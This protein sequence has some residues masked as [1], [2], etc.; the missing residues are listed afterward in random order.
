MS[1]KHLFN[2]RASCQSREG[3][4]GKNIKLKEEKNNGEQTSSMCFEREA[5]SK[6]MCRTADWRR[7]AGLPGC[8]LR[9]AP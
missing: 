7:L 9:T 1:V 2:P 3:R 4:G 8:V 6:Q 5:A